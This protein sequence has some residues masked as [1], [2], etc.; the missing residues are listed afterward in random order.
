MIL[1]AVDGTERVVELH[2]AQRLTVGIAV[3]GV[4][5]V[6]DVLVHLKNLVAVVTEVGIEVHDE[7]A[8]LDQAVGI[9]VELPTRVTHLTIIMIGNGQ[10][11]GVRRNTEVAHQHVGGCRA[12]GLDGEVQSVVEQ[13][14]VNT[15][16]VL[17]HELPLQ[18][19]QTD[20]QRLHGSHVHITGSRAVL[21]S[22]QVVLAGL[23]THTTPAGTE[24]QH[25]KCRFQA[26][27]PR[28]VTHNPLQRNR[29]EVTPAVAGT[30]LSSTVGTYGEVGHV[31]SLISIVSREGVVHRAP[32]AVAR[33]HAVDDTTCR[34]AH[35]DTV[36][37]RQ[38][39]TVG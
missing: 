7:L 13:S 5:V 4:Q 15:E 11:T 20:V 31:A 29:G 12:I 30:E 27:H 37:R 16:V 36:G 22:V 28:L 18:V 39:V 14:D 32:L 17:R 25:R 38:A 21:R 23:V 3:G 19:G 24:G 34:G 9:D 2:T 33:A 26:L 1:E 6:Q 8:L 35:D 10:E